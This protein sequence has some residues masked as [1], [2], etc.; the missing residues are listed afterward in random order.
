MLSKEDEAT[1]QFVEETNLTKGQLRGEDEVTLHPGAGRKPFIM[2]HTLMWPE[3]IDMLPTRMCEL[4]QWYM[5]ASVE[6]YVMLAARIKYIYFHRGMD[7]VWIDFDNLWFLYH[8]DALD[9]SLVS[10]FAIKV[11]PLILYSNSTKYALSHPLLLF[12]IV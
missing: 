1:A 10:T 4:H 3:L 9:K 7:D 6:G 11:F 5:K 8:Q 12:L 2:G